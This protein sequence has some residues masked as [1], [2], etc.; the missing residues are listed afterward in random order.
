MATTKTTWWDKNGDV[1]EGYIKDGQTFIDEEGKTRVPV[2]ATVKTNGGTYK[3]TS[4]GGVPTAATARKQYET[5]TNAAISAYEAAGKAQEDRINAAT[6][7]AIAEYNRQKQEAEQNREQANREAQMAYLAASNPYGA[8]GEQMAKIGLSDSGYSETAKLRLASDYAGQIS[9]NI[10]DLNKQLQNIDIQIAQAK[11]SGQYELANMLE[12]RAQNVMQQK[13]AMENNLSSLDMQAI[14]QAE[15]TRQ[16][17]ENMAYQAARDAVLDERHKTEWDYGVGRDKVEDE[18]RDKEF[19]Y[20]VKQDDRDYNYKLV[21]AAAAAAGKKEGK[22]EAYKDVLATAKTFKT[23]K[24]AADYLTRAAAEGYITTDDAAYI[25][26]A[27]LGFDENDVEKEEQDSI[28]P[29]VQIYKK[30]KTDISEWLEEYGKTY[31]LE[32]ERLYKFIEAAQKKQ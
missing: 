23:A 22:S 19:N 10:R 2:G 9:A 21:Q 24:D 16:W 32:G 12:A 8:M 20:M 26:G 13:V 18:W 29:I 11:A 6:N 25:Y 28:K 27:V 17:E 4:S 7:A 3:M 14:A 15:Q 1:H 5:K 30:S 31:G